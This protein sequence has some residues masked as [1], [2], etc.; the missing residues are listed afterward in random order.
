MGLE[1]ASMLLESSWK[2]SLVCV[3]GSG[4]D[5]ERARAKKAE[6]VLKFQAKEQRENYKTLKEG[7]NYWVP[8]LAHPSGL[9]PLFIV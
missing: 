2:S 3:E 8:W 5:A 6:E 7:G 4:E 1:G 9:P